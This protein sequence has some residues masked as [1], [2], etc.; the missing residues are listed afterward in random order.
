MK[1][2]LFIIIAALCA[3]PAESEVLTNQSIIDLVA[4]GL[5]ENVIVT[6]IETSECNF[7][8]SL[9]AIKK[10]NGEGIAGNI[11]VAMMSASHDA[12]TAKKAEENS[13]SGIYYIESDSVQKQVL[14]TVFSGTKANTLGAVFSAGIASTKVMAIINGPNSGMQVRTSK[15]EF[16]FVFN[17]E[18]NALSVTDWWFSSSNSPRQFALVKLKVKK[19]DRQLQMGKVNAYA[20]LDMSVDQKAKIDFD[21]EQESEGVF[22]VIPKTPLEP[23]EYCFFFQGTLPSKSVSNNSVFDFSVPGN[24]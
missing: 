1:K 18:T 10:L 20:G 15:P 13:K 6:K 3:L 7:D 22:R 12:A 2:T 23:G 4:L 19:N 14:P 5:P 11:L 21:V 16:R 8:T 24:E 9:E 17:A